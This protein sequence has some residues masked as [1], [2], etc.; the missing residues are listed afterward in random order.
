MTVLLKENGVNMTANDEH[1]REAVTD[2]LAIIDRIGYVAARTS[3]C[4]LSDQDAM[5]HIHQIFDHPDYCS[6]M[7]RA[8]HV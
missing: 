8:R 4:M 2:L 3:P 7:A 6:A 1:L 5:S